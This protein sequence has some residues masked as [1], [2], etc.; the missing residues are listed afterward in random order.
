MS[1]KSLGT[2]R[3]QRWH[4][5]FPAAEVGEGDGVIAFTAGELAGS[6]RDCAPRLGVHEAM[7]AARLPRAGAVR[8]RL[9]GYRGKSLIGMLSWLVT[10]RLATADAEVLWCLDKQQ[11]PDSCATL[12]KELG[13][14]EV[15]RQRDGKLFRIS[16]LPPMEAEFPQARQFT[17]VIGG[18][19]LSFF[20]DYGVF[21][22]GR[23]DDGTRWLAE[24][25]LG[26]APVT[27]VADIGVGYGP[28]AVALVCNGVAQHAV[29]TDVDCLALW[30]AQRNA[31]LNGVPMQVACTPDPLQVAGTPLTVCNVPTHIDSSQSADLMRGLVQRARGDRMLMIVVHASLEARYT[32]HLSAAGLTPIRH[33]GKQH[34]VLE[35]SEAHIG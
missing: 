16:G 14:R 30:L 12:L 35:V 1:A 2:E 28:L 13:W 4:I 31:D 32:K 3:G 23:V 8:V 18:R 27:T 24:V 17:A 33:P 26:L 11:G 7:A 20:A 25:A 21:S 29:A 9:P 19:E 10:M 6:S 22:P 5:G 15:S 34:V